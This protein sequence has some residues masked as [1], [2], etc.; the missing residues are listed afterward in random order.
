MSRFAP[1]HRISRFC[2]RE[3]NF[4]AMFT[5]FLGVLLIT[6]AVFLIVWLTARLVLS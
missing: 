3:L 2:F 5:S 4:P 1:A 6:L